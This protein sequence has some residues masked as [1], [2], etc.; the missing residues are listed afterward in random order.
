MD[1]RVEGNVQPFVEDRAVLNERNSNREALIYHLRVFDAETNKVIGYIDDISTTGARLLSEEPIPPHKVCRYRM[2]LPRFYEGKKSVE[3]DAV[4][5]WS[6][7]DCDRCDFCDSGVEFV[8]LDP[9]EKERISQLIG[10]Y[11]I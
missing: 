10:G 2:E 3:F 1:Q 8:E 11:H 9:M 6:E 4:T 7:G 5:A